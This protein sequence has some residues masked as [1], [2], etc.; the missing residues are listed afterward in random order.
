V[1]ILGEVKVMKAGPPLYNDIVVGLDSASVHEGRVYV[2]GVPAGVDLSEGLV[3]KT[4][5]V[6]AGGG[7]G[8][9]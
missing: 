6:L 3:A 9:V 7:V 4:G 5:A 2:R 1:T 8:A